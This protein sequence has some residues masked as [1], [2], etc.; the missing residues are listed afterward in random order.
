MRQVLATVVFMLSVSGLHAQE[1]AQG[2]DPA[3]V[4]SPASR[5][6]PD[7][8]RADG[9]TTSRAGSW[10]VADGHADDQRTQEEQL[11]LTQQRI[12]VQIAAAKAAAQAQHGSVDDGYTDPPIGGHSMLRAIENEDYGMQRRTYDPRMDAGASQAR[13]AAPTL[14][15]QIGSALIQDVG[16]I[17]DSHLQRKINGEH[18]RVILPRYDLDGEPP[19]GP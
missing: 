1:G 16:G 8:A 14:G 10:P 19:A 13:A 9:G 4:D 12:E 2:Q 15:Q 17:A 7:P 11:A 18:G 5:A 6:M 3:Y